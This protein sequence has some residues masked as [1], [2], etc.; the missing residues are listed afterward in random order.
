VI[1]SNCGRLRRACA[2]AGTVIRR[3]ADQAGDVAQDVAVDVLRSLTR[4]REPEAFDAWVHR[5][6]VRHALRAAGRRR[7]RERAET[8][9][10]NAAE[11][12]AMGA[13]HDAALT[14]R[15]V[16]RDGLARLPAKQRLALALRYVHDLTDE[17]IAA[18]LGCETGTVRALLSRGRSAL[19]RDETLAQLSDVTGGG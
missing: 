4:L 18:A 13:D 5:I 6:T 12:G 7:G 8:A 3:D 19:R 9:L 17:E 2:P 11:L 15:H 10:D 16:L 1:R 14:A